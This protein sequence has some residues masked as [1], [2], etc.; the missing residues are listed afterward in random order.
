MILH[1]LAVTVTLSLLIPGQCFAIA[2]EVKSEKVIT[3]GAALMIMDSFT[4]SPDNKRIAY[5]THVTPSRPEMMVVLDGKPMAPHRRIGDLVFS[6]N[7]MRLAFW[8]D[9]QTQIG[10]GGYVI[11][12]GVHRKKYEGILDRTL[13]F[14]PDSKRLA[15]GV[16]VDKKQFV[17]VDEKEGKPYDG[18]GP[19]SL[20]FSP[21]S[22]RMAYV[23]R[24]GSKQFLVMDGKEA[25]EHFDGIS[26]SSLIFRRRKGVRNRF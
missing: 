13:I 17:V 16:E 23:A 7:S 4:V 18:T 24:A 9:E 10:A 14:S 11:V 6:P 22:S 2:R 15:Y 25:Q 19:N 21:D 5:V 26:G 20:I 1:L 3:Q 12:D 8:V